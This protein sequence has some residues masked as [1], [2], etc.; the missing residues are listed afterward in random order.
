MEGSIPRQ[1]KFIR[2][3]FFLLIIN[4]SLIGK[5]RL[6]LEKADVLESKMVDGKIIQ[7]LSGNVV[8]RKGDLSLKCEEGRNY[9]K[10]EIANLFRNVIATKERTIL[11]CDTLIFFSKEN[12]IVSNGNPHVYDDDFDLIAD[13]II[14]FTEQDSGIALGEVR[15]KQKGQTINANR[16]E[17]KKMLDQDGVSYTAIGKVSIKDS[18]RIVT[19]GEARYDQTNEVTTLEIEPEI[20]ENGRI[21]NGEKIIL[22][23]KNEILY[24]LHIP[25]KAFVITPVSG[26]K[27]TES[28]SISSQDS[29]QFLDNMEGSI[30]TGYF[31]DGVLDSI[32]LEGM[33]KSLYHIFEDSLYQG[34]N[35]T[36]GDTITI[37]FQNNDIDNLNVIGGSRGKYKPDKAGTDMEFPII[38]S[39]DKIQYRVPTEKTDLSGQAKIKHDKTDLEAGFIT[40][41]W[42]NNMLNA[43]PQ[44]AQDTIF[45]LIQPVIKEKG[46]DPMTGD[47]ITYNLET[48][49][50]R[51]VKGSTNADEGYYTGNEIRNE[52]EKVIFI[53]NSTYT[54]C[55]SEIPHFHFESSRMKIIQNDMVIARPII[56]HL[57]QIPIMGIPL[58]IFPHKGGSRHSGWIM[59]SY[60]ESKHRGQYIDGLGFYWA[61]NNYWDS[62]FTMSMGDRQGIVFH[63]NNNYRLRYKFSGNFNIRSKQFLSG[64]NNIVNLGSSRKSDLYLR[65]N[66]SQVLRNNQSFNANVTYSSTGDYNKKYG[67]TQAD[68][69]NQ[70]AI[71]NISYSKRWPKSKNSISANFYSNKDLLINDKVNPES[72][73]YINPS[74]AGTQLNIINRTIPKISFRHGQSN[75]IPT[76]AKNKKWYNNIT[77]NYGLNFTNKDRDYYESKENTINDS[78]IVFQWSKQEN[79]ELITHNDQKQGWI[80]TTS[81]NAPQKILKYIT[82]NPRL[83][84]RSVWVNESFDGIWDKNT[85]SFTKSLKK[86]FASRTTGSFSLSSNTKLY[87]MFPIPFGPL[88]VIRHTASPS[89]SFSYTPDFSKPVL[90]R[91]L[92]YVM[93]NIDTAGNKIIFDRFA[94]TMAGGTP[95]SK[96]KSMNFSLNN[97]FQGKIKKGGEEKKV[98]LLSWRMSSGYNFAAE[99]FQLS[100]MRSS[101]RSRIAGKLNLDFS[102]THDFYQYKSGKG[103]ISRLNKNE[104][105]MLSPR[106]TNARF[107]TGFR[108]SGKRWSLTDPVIQNPDTLYEEEDLDGPGLDKSS[109][110][111]RNT[112]NNDQLWSTN[113]SLSYSYSALNPEQIKKTFWINTSSSFQVTQK[114]KVSY[115]ARFDM[116]KRDLVNHSFSV[117]RDLHCWELSLNWTPGGIG[118]GVNFRI[119]VKSPTLRDL[120]IEKRGGVY[121]RSPF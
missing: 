79:G 32:R 58:G 13:S 42:K 2:I 112:L 22:T 80:H 9:E 93:T 28:D 11:T 83:N 68:R 66:H 116:M 104:K 61:P 36:S 10:E 17:Y 91:N 107:S 27:K 84:L 98:D 113:L 118:Q 33:A 90:G 47:K 35:E 46:K 99:E 59:P 94:G 7:Y 4:S 64:S 56:L 48:R 37:S 63:I 43:L 25:D 77:W 54:T 1:M 60:G 3:L 76:T 105:G 34:N 89:I 92:G 121:S 85:G 100:N 78:T 51:M 49:K 30:L 101:L 12:R 111:F 75:L 38:Y 71:S 119:N 117:Y 86:G 109:K 14:V 87:G 21:L 26:Y 69:M 70:K 97:I 16:I 23:Y 29:V 55:D 82:L 5:D 8:I 31:I 53:Q 15:L 88:K 44:P 6:R 39:A 114:W 62:K 120:K 74:R 41:D 115:R 103:R 96:S 67:L 45:K 81:I 108:F 72:S 110:S 102:F 52:S 18:S 50:G 57:A 19:C 24:K 73:F 106:M 40:V 20:N 65:W 95:R